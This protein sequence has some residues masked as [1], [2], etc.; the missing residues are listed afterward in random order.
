MAVI[1]QHD[2][3]KDYKDIKVFNA[4]GKKISLNEFASVNNNFKVKDFVMLY[5][6]NEFVIDVEIEFENSGRSYVFN[7]SFK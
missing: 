3:D 4:L 7:N 2:D 6:E 5:S 1:I